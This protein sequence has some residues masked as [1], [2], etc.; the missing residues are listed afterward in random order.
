MNTS[1]KYGLIGAVLGV[2]SAAASASPLTVVDLI[3]GGVILGGIG[4]VIGKVQENKS[5]K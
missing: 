1:Q 2:V 5:K 4:F 3:T